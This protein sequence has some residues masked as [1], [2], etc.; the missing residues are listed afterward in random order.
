MVTGNS[1][2]W[3]REPAREERSSKMEQKIWT[4]GGAGRTHGGV[5]G[6]V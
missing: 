1:P 6:E 2:Q 5:E 3:P 4:H